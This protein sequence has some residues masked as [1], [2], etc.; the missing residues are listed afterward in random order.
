MKKIA[1]LFPGQ[2]SQY[3][4]MAKD[5]AENFS[6]IDL[7]FKQ[8]DSI[9]N[10]GLTDL[11]FNGPEDE[12]K[13]T[14]NT[15]PAILLHSIAIL[16][17]LEN[18]EIKVCFA[19]G[20]SLGEY[21]SHVAAQSLGFKDALEI[22]RLR[23]ELMFQS[24]LKR[25]GTMA[26]IINLD[27]VKIEELCA[28][29]SQFGICQPANYNSPQQVVISGE[30]NG[31]EKGMEIAKKMG[32]AKV[33]QLPVSGAFH[34]ALMTDAKAG[35]A[36]RLNRTVINPADFPVVANFSAREVQAADDIRHA[37]I[38][39]LDHPVRWI[40]SMEYLAKQNI[41]LFIEAGPGNVLT[42]LLKRIDRSQ[43]VISVDK[44]NDIDK[45]IQYIND[46]DRKV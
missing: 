45:V 36:E 7:L 34:S 41:D 19:A 12:L 22:V 46:E 27:L 24:G 43:K 14:K 8:A 11:M 16:K 38:E 21:S 23:G 3:V 6:E 31:V 9:L 13:L 39:Q 18:K 2:G 40:E 33:V 26:A 5:L 28:E 1:L 25:P 17:L 10:F 20:H 37:L 4:G 35:L 42:G 32:A 29:A 44:A 30:V 15:Q